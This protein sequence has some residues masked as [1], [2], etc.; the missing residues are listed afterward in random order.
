MRLGTVLDVDSSS[1]GGAVLVLLCW[2]CHSATVRT[3][4][5][6]LAKYPRVD[7]QTNRLDPTSLIHLLPPPHT[8]LHPA[9]TQQSFTAKSPAAAARPAL[10]APRSRPAGPTE[11]RRPRTR[12]RA[13]PRPANRQRAAIVPRHF[14]DTMSKHA[15]TALCESTAR[16]NYFADTLSEHSMRQ[17][18]CA[19]AHIHLARIRHA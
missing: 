19:T 16:G 7:R 8:P 11:A 4:V 9:P 6:I 3:E 12:K 13:T 2:W 15:A 1:K 17:E 5:L 18:Y 10:P 14:P